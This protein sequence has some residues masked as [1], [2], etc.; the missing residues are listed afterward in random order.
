MYDS[1]PPRKTGG[2]FLPPERNK[3]MSRL[4]T[5]AKRIEKVMPEFVE[6]VPPTERSEGLYR[7][8]RHIQITGECC[9]HKMSLE[10][11]KEII[12]LA[13][14]ESV[15]DACLY[16][17]R[18]LDRLHIERTLETAN[19][20]LKLDRRLYYVSSKIKLAMWQ[21]KY[22]SDLIHG[23]YSEN[24]IACA[25]EIAMKKKN[26]QAYFIGIFKKGYKAPQKS[27]TL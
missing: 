24:D 13:G 20:R 1:H 8:I 25:L 18:V 19:N 27:P 7:R 10:Q 14:R 22:L 5:M 4:E 15:R 21:M 3:R 12:A 11:L 2:S 16:L 26:P 9:G 17:C 6:L 23:K